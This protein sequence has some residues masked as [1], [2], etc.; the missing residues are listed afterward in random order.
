[1]TTMTADYCGFL[2]DVIALLDQAAQAAR[3]QVTSIAVD[4]I[5]IHGA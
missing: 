2:C 3:F 1:V 5:R 4:A